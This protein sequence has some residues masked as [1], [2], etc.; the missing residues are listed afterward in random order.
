[1][2]R[3]ARQAESAQQAAINVLLSCSNI[4]LFINQS[5]NSGSDL[6]GTC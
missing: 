4:S 2:R 5:V 1:L 6:A 3:A